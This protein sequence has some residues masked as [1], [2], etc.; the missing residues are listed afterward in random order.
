MSSHRSRRLKRI[1][2]R[3]F[4]HRPAPCA[5]E[6]WSQHQHHRLVQGEQ[7]RR[8]LHLRQ[9]RPSRRWRH[10][11]PGA[12][13]ARKPLR[14]HPASSP[15][16]LPQP[17]RWPRVHDRRAA[18]CRKKRLPCPASPRSHGCASS[19]PSSRSRCRSS[20]EGRRSRRRG[21][22]RHLDLA[23]RSRSAAQSQKARKSRT[24]SRKR[25]S[26]SHAVAALAPVL[27]SCH[28]PTFQ[29]RTSRRHPPTHLSDLASRH[30]FKRAS[31]LPTQHL[32]LKMQLASALAQAQ[33][34]ASRLCRP[35][36]QKWTRIL[37]RRH[38]SPRPSMQR[39]LCKMRPTKAQVRWAASRRRRHLR[40][41]ERTKSRGL[42]LPRKRR[43]PSR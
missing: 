14:R 31:C 18:V 32:H 26:P 19:L 10:P 35:N 1:S 20:S 5:A 23:R 34:A 43:S 36:A 25:A 21:R 38:G 17:L 2:S 13:H 30:K 33:A 37:P 7:S 22:C 8:P 6:R 24:G 41:R 11:S 28:L 9:G 16:R 40:Q 27:V 15:L 39:L 3:Q 12:A 42:L 29:T 4:R